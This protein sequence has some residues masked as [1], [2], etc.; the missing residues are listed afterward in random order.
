[1]TLEQYKTRLLEFITVRLREVYE[2]QNNGF[3]TSAPDELERMRAIIG[4]EASGGPTFL[5]ALEK[6]EHEREWSKAN[7][8]DAWHGL[9]VACRTLD[10]ML[11]EE[12]K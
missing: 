3:G 4:G 1:M 5:D 10:G 6:L 12:V 2:D 7:N 11:P 8:P 9:Q